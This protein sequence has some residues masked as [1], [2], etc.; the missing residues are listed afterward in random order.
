MIAE[1]YDATI[2]ALLG[3]CSGP[4]FDMCGW[5]KQTLTPEQ[6]SRSGLAA[7]IPNCFCS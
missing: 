2:T 7:Q 1:A 3:T 6:C 4:S 5:L